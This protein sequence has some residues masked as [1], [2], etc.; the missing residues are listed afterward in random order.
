MTL[1][2]SHNWRGVSLIHP[3]KVLRK[4]GTHE[5]ERNQPLDLGA[6]YYMPKIKNLKLQRFYFEVMAK[7]TIFVAL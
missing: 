2:L 7:L 1:P 6:A 5:D 4:E 3:P